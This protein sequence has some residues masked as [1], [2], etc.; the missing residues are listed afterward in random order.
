MSSIASMVESR[1][2][3]NEVEVQDKLRDLASATPNLNFNEIVQVLINSITS[4]V[5][6]I[7]MRGKNATDDEMKRRS[8]QLDTDTH[9][10]M[11]AKRAASDADEAWFECVRDEKE[12]QEFEEEKQQEVERALE[13]TVIPCTGR[14]DNRIYSREVQE[15]KQL[16]CDFSQG[17]Q[18][19][20]ELQKIEQAV[21]ESLQSLEQ[22]VG[23][24]KSVWTGY[25]EQCNKAWEAHARADE[26]LELAERDR[27]QKQGECSQLK[28]KRGISI[29]TFGEAL[30]VKCA[31][32]SSYNQIEEQLDQ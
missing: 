5:Q 3:G 10:A 12:L 7:I 24:Q 31:A 4:D 8:Q 13:V 18:C 16:T 29:C 15:P 26:A 6:S 21:T 30:Q 28:G 2:A 11:E 22:E 23:H 32:F 17:D 27:T 1:K 14:D 25:N 20:T 19:D 9:A